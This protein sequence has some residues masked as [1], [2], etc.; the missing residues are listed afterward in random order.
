MLLW[1]L[2]GFALGVAA[3]MLRHNTEIKLAWYDWVMLVFAI[4][5]F[6]LA[7]VNFTGSMAELE[8]RAAW[9]MLAAFGVPGLILTAIVGVRVWRGYQTAQPTSAPASMKTSPEPGAAK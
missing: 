7:Y 6:V 9:F 1:L 5:F 3:I 4:I 2:V 8:P